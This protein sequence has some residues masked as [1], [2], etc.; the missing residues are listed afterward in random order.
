MSN[1]KVVFY[2]NPI[3]LQ[4][5]ASK[6]QLSQ[7]NWLFIH[8]K[9]ITEEKTLLQLF[10]K[11]EF[12]EIPFFRKLISRVKI[13]KNLILKFLSSAQKRAKIDF[14]LQ[15]SKSTG[16]RNQ[17]LTE[18][19]TPEIYNKVETLSVKIFE[20]VR[21]LPL[22]KENFLFN[23]LNL[24]E[25][26]R[27]DFIKHFYQDLLNIFCLQ[28]LIKKI[29]PVNVYML[30]SLATNNNLMISSL[31]K[32]LNLEIEKINLKTPKNRKFINKLVKFIPHLVIDHLWYWNIW[33]IFYRDPEV[34]RSLK[35]P[36]KKN[37]ILSH[38]LNHFPSLMPLLGQ[39][40]ESENIQN[41]LYV[42]HKLYGYSKEK[43]NL[44]RIKNVI[45]F[46]YEYK[47]YHAF[48]YRYKRF[49]NVI[50]QIMISPL[51]NDIKAESINLG[52]LV[53]Y[54]FLKL[55]LKLVQSLYYIENF[56]DALR[57][58][59]PNIVCMLNG[60]DS[61]DLLATFISKKFDTPTLFFPHGVNSI[62]YEY[63]KFNQDYVICPG[64]KERD[65]FR[66]LG[67]NEK[68][69]HTL[70][71]PLYDTLYKKYSHLKDTKAI[72]AGII[73]KFNLNPENR[74]ISLVTTHYDDYIRE[75]LFKSVIDL[76]KSLDNCQLIVKIHPVEELS[77]YRKLSTKYNAQEINIVKDINLYDIIIASD[78]I[79]GKGTGAELE[80][81][82]LDKMVVDV[83][84]EGASD[85]FQL[86]RF[87]AVIP[88]DDSGELEEKVKDALNSDHFSNAL[89]EGRKKYLEYCVSKFDG[90]ASLRVKKLIEQII[91][92]N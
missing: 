39:F 50:N 90:N 70:G 75:K 42:P 8:I 36:V 31:K 10:F 57:K 1:T 25:I 46:P 26:N 79:I 76:M 4:S 11:N 80:A 58:L 66:L 3:D 2:D 7:G 34:K 52:N 5:F 44:E 37:L 73:K 16:I 35:K 23:N 32:D 83:D 18:F 65:Y 81:I 45:V 84:Y 41:I 60:N 51:L 19:A 85:A 91:S 53:R 24:Y 64:N 29:K 48:R 74:I 33:K 38:Y 49:K 20:K 22:I 43:I 21:D 54:S 6:L 62:S 68:N 30:S 47:N 88:V 14:N 56:N 67:T 86:R 28:N 9:A 89:K 15:F 59:N 13:L 78:I 77:Y 61:M 63:G 92:K 87:G 72:R 27:L 69:I 55:H 71:I 82:F 40:K 17:L 12:L